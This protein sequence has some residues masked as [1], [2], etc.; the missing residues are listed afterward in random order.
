MTFADDSDD[1]RM[2][3]ASLRSNSSDVHILL[4][5]LCDELSDTL[6]DRLRIERAGGRFHK[7]DAI[8]SVSI[9]IAGSQ[10]EAAVDGAALQC[11]VGHVSGG[12]RIRSESV[13]I[14]Q[15]ILRLLEALKEEA[16]HSDSARRALENIVI[17]GNQ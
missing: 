11:H 9:S 6:G 12:I 14:D 10:F 13:D 15:W 8:S 5:A 1:L 4:K 7:S 2:A 16:A 17:G 3:A